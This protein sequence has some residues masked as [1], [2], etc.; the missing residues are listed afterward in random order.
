ML[1]EVTWQLSPHLLQLKSFKNCKLCY[2][3]AGLLLQST[4][5]F[6]DQYLYLLLG[7]VQ[8]PLDLTNKAKGIV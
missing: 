4:F 2:V 6:A 8:V 3:E 5:H 1:R 7:L